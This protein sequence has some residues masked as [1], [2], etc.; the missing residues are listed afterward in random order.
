MATNKIQ[1]GKDAQASA[2]RFLDMEEDRRAR[3]ESTAKKELEREG[4]AAGETEE[5]KIYKEVIRVCAKKP[6]ITKIPGGGVSI[7]ITET[8][9]LRTEIKEAITEAGLN[10]SKVIGSHAQGISWIA[11]SK[12]RIRETDMK[13]NM[14]SKKAK[15]A[16]KA[17]GKEVHLT[18]SMSGA[19]FEG[20]CNLLYIP[21]PPKFLPSKLRNTREQATNQQH[22]R[23]V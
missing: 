20:V 23:E 10:L 21:L 6:Q 5:S 17:E 13:E 3:A 1:Q 19:V 11:W 2:K 4:R 12:F 18:I 16:A 7:T 15:D 22:T 9:E 14:P 8:N